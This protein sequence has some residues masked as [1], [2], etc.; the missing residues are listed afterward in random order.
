MYAE[1]GSLYSIKGVSSW[2]GG[3]ILSARCTSEA[4]ST[5]IH[6]RKNFPTFFA[7]YETVGSTALLSLKRVGVDSAEGS[8]LPGYSLWLP[9][10]PCAVSDASTLLDRPR[11]RGGE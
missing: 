8:D 10:Y 9:F 6:A 7:M 2:H 1:S 5:A 3:A 11:G 4:D